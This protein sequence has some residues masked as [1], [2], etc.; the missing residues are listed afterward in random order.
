MPYDILQCLHANDIIQ[1]Y[2]YTLSLNYL[3]NM[4]FVFSIRIIK[5]LMHP[6]NYLTFMVDINIKLSTYQYYICISG[7]II[8]I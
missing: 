4:Q 1:I 2:Y 8:V 3:N 5:H 6:I 7:I